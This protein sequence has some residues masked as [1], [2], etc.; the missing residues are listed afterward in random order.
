MSDSA[1]GLLV[2][3]F[4]LSIFVGY[5][6]NVIE[7]FKCNFEPIGKAEIVRTIGVFVPPIGVVA[8]YIDIEDK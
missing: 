8:G 6:F 3:V 2:I 7:L 4:V 1:K 5:I